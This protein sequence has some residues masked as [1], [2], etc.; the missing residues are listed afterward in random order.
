MQEALDGLPIV[1]RWSGAPTIG[2]L[3]AP[4]GRNS[5]EGDGN[6]LGHVWH[7]DP[8]KYKVV[9]Y[10]KANDVWWTKPTFASPSTRIAD[11]GSWT[12]DVSTGGSDRNAIQYAAFLLPADVD[13]PL[14]S[15]SGELPKELESYPRA[16]VYRT[17][18]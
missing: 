7:V 14:L 6:L 11:D 18:K 2:I 9:V 16:D 8:R 13:P 3:S 1:D 12:T 15:G 4:S 5:E 10:L 17:L